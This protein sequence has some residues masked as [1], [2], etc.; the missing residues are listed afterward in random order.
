[1]AKIKIE[2]DTE[3]GNLNSIDLGM[4]MPLTPK[5]LGLLSTI[6]LTQSLYDLFVDIKQGYG[7][8]HSV[9]QGRQNILTEGT[10]PNI[11]KSRTY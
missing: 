7:V 11:R 8:K 1:M 4:Q 3:N 5:K 10:R 2:I 9:N 6:N